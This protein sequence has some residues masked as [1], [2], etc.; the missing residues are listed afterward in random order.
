MLGSDGKQIG[1]LPKFEALTRAKAEGLDLVEIAP[2]AK[3][4]VAKIV[5]FNKFM[6][7]EEKKKKEE[8]KKT[9]TSETKELRLGPFMDGHDLLVVVRKARIFLGDG[10]KVKFVVKF[11]GRQITHPE[12]GEEVLGKV[13]NELSDISKIEREKHFEGRQLIAMLS[14]DK[15]AGKKPTPESDGEKEEKENAEEKNKKIS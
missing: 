13:I 14:P 5:N 2:T 8:K 1:I 15:K 4:P 11:A 10:N 6:Y 12:F 7:Q 9:K 3:P